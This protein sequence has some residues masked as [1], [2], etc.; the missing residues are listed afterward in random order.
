MVEN[1]KGLV[2]SRVVDVGGYEFGERKQAW[3]DVCVGRP[4]YWLLA[5]HCLIC[6]CYQPQIYILIHTHTP[7]LF[8]MVQIQRP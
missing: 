5:S 2:V 8:E 1:G 4:H 7:F 6:L 3:I